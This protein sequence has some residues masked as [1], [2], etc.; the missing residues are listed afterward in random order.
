M[1]KIAENVYLK[2]YYGLF[3]GAFDLPGGVLCID[4]PLLPDET[5]LWR[6]DLMRLRRGSERL[7][8][9]LDMNPDR[10]LGVRN[11]DMTVLAHQRIAD[12]LAGR[13][14]TYRS[15]ARQGLYLESSD[16]AVSLRWPSVTLSFSEEIE[17]HWS[18]TPIVIRHMPGPR[19]E[20]CWVIWTAQKVVFVG[21]AVSQEPP[22]LA[23]A[24]LAQWL[25]SLEVLL[26]D[27]FKRYTIVS[28]RSG[29]LGRANVREQIA[30]LEQLQRTLDELA[31]DPS[32]DMVARQ[33]ENWLKK[34]QAEGPAQQALFQMRLLYGFQRQLERDA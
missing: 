18:D 14:A 10:I 13:P 28:G 25:A 4:A 32:P 34:Y 16:I 30:R 33:V 20:S 9:P 5:R 12:D 17:I 7:V 27:D 19:P 1:E 26:G 15:E 11:M 2:R 22:F 24:D 23:D 3:V 21:D 6:G 31:A 29:P 8:F